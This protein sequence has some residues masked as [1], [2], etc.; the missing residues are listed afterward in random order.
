[1]SSLLNY[2]D[3]V[4][5]DTGGSISSVSTS[6]GTANS[7]TTVDN[8]I[9]VYYEPQQYYHY[10][11]NLGTE[12]KFD[13][14]ADKKNVIHPR[15][16]FRFVKS[17]LT[18]LEE[19]KLNKRLLLLQKFVK[20]AEDMG[21]QALYEEFSRKIA[22]TVREQELWACGIEYFLDKKY[23][24]Q[25]MDKVKDVEIGFSRLE[26][27]DRPLPAQ[28]ERKVKKI[29]KLKLFDELWVLYLNYKDK[30]DIG[31]IK[32]KD[33]GL[34]TN[35]EKIKEK[36]PILF[37]VQSYMPNKLYYIIDWIDEYCDLT[38]DKFIED[39]KK[40]DPDYDV[41]KL[42]DIDE[43]Y[44]QKLVKESRDRHKR[45]E[46][47]NYKNYKDLMKEEDKLTKISKSVLLSVKDFLRKKKD[48]FKK[49]KR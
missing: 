8:S 44:I 14:A 5:F 2:G 7:W 23:V 30:E 46:N 26:N 3:S 28:V 4:F 25:F 6:S 22:T 43:K 12:I 21:Q 13:F 47:T 16:Y 27:F 37:G 39:V 31:G 20:S 18:K 38:L 1:M 35:K 45:L 15:L 29:R 40:S 33:G 36:D 19:R 48:V 9:H 41:Y 34:K 32:K 10:G 24:T 49:I 17:K 11:T 42:D